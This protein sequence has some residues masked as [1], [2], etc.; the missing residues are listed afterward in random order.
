MS[1]DTGLASSQV[2]IMEFG[3]LII[4]GEQT[5][6]RTCFSQDELLSVVSDLFGELP[7]QMIQTN[8]AFSPGQE[9]FCLQQCW[10]KEGTFGVDLSPA[11]WK[12]MKSADKIHPVDNLGQNEV[13]HADV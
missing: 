11:V 2:R 3:L 12:P 1:L 6:K 7:W 8:T 10:G 13:S 5:Q 9:Q 4:I